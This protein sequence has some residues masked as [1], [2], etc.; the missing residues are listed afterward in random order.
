MKIR[1]PKKERVVQLRRHGYEVSV[2]KRAH[3]QPPRST[4][5]LRMIAQIISS[6]AILAASVTALEQ[7][8]K[9]CAPRHDCTKIN[10]LETLARINS[11][12]KWC[13]AELMEKLAR[14]AIL[15]PDV[16]WNW[17]PEYDTE[18]TNPCLYMATQ[19]PSL[20]VAV[21]NSHA[22]IVCSTIEPEFPA[23]VGDVYSYDYSYPVHAAWSTNHVKYVNYNST[24]FVA[25]PLYFRDGTVSTVVF[26]KAN[27]DLP[28]ICCENP[29]PTLTQCRRFH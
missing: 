19:D 14:R 6:L 1:L 9:R 26:S 12:P 23:P 5:Q 15:R 29:D 7:K 24:T 25:V 4:K 8:N 3:K 17:N 21:V 18:E 13:G 10:C 2:Y 11:E 22:Q 27:A 20:G 16:N 28:I